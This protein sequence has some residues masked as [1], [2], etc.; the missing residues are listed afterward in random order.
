MKR[1]PHARAPLPESFMLTG[2]DGQIWP[3]GFTSDLCNPHSP[4]SML[5]TLKQQLAQHAN[6][7]A[8]E[9]VAESGEGWAGGYMGPL[10]VVAPKIVVRRP[11]QMRM[12]G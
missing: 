4:R 5:R 9:K 3:P 7:I 10:S 1:K 8:R 6:R 12:K 2:R 11:Q